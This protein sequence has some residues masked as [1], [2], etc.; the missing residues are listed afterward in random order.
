[1]MVWFRRLIFRLAV[2]AELLELFPIVLVIL[3]IRL[4]VIEKT[5]LGFGRH[6]IRTQVE[7]EVR[8]ALHPPKNSSGWLPHF[9]ANKSHR[10]LSS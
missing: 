7:G 9:R 8:A 1:M 5:G 2:S 10:S 6:V 3:C 4:C